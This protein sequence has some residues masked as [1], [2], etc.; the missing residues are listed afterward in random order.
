MSIPE[1]NTATP[2]TQNAQDSLEQKVTAIIS[3]STYDAETNKVSLPDKLKDTLNADILYAITLEHRR[4]NTQSSYTKN[5]QKTKALEA[6]NSKLA[7]LVSGVSKV[8]IPKEDLDR[9]DALMYEDP[10]KWRKEL[11]IVEKKAIGETKAKIAELTSEAKDAAEVSFELNRREQVLSLFNESAE[12]QITEELIANEVPPRI[13]KKL[14]E[15][16]VTF[17][18]F[19]DEVAIY[20]GKGKVIKNEDILDQPNMGDLGG[21]KTPDNTKSDKGLAEKYKADLY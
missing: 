10:Q 11:D 18:E 8:E 17:E 4:R 1:L 21:S 9:L 15:G 20:V 2:E 7:E 13:T 5:Q 12:L 19:L 6:E 14:A 3:Q 16:K